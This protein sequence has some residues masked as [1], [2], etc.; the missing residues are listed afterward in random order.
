MEYKLSFYQINIVQLGLAAW[1]LCAPA[2]LKT[3]KILAPKPSG[4]ENDRESSLRSLLASKMIENPRF[5]ASWRRQ[6]LENARLETSRRRKIVENARFE[7]SVT[8]KIMYGVER[9][10][11]KPIE[12][13]ASK[14]LCSKTL[15]SVHFMHGST[16][17]IYVTGSLLP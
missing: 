4:I 2:A 5:E 13:L 14:Q 17:I 1:G 10:I 3:S 8:S 9:A 12:E 15:S 11:K 16:L 7:A 6:M